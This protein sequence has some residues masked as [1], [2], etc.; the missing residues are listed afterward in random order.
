MRKLEHYPVSEKN[1][2]SYLWKFRSLP[3]TIFNFLIIYS[4]RFLPFL[5]WKR[6]LLRLT[7]MK[8]GKEVSIGM[9]VVFDVLWPELIEI[10]DNCII[11]YNT[12]ILAH[13][14]LINEMRLGKVKIG[15]N[16]MI[17]ANSTILAGVTIG[18]GVTVSAMSLVNDDLP[19]NSF[20]GGIPAHVIKGE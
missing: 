10:D 20:C 13:E 8:I 18:E 6:F 1:S 12:T 5:S 2:L 3:R 7:G 17:G 14:F 4:T 9:G 11:G 16:V 19:D 15:K